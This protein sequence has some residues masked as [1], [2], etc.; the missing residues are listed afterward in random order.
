MKSVQAPYPQLCLIG[1]YYNDGA[2]LYSNT[3]LETIET[4]S[5]GRNGVIKAKLPEIQYVSSAAEFRILLGVTEAIAKLKHSGIEVLVVTQSTQSGFGYDQ[6]ESIHNIRDALQR[7]LTHRDALIGCYYF[8]PHHK[9]SCSRRKPLP[10]LYG[11]SV[12]EFP[13]TGPERALTAGG[14][15]SNVELGHR[16][17]MSTFFIEGTV[18]LRKLARAASLVT[19]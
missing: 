8:C 12:R 15:L 1:W 4:V 7:R 14:S 10:G 17:D 2:E 5:L 13:A 18:G 16:L 6:L 3:G 19:H 9:R 11:E